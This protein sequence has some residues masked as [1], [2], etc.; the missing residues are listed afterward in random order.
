MAKQVP[1]CLI[2]LD[3]LSFDLTCL[4]GVTLKASPFRNWIGGCALVGQLCLL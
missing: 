4:D 3:S 1:V 2:K